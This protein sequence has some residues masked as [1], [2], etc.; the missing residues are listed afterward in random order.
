MSKFPTLPNN[1]SQWQLPPSDTTY[2]LTQRHLEK[3]G[4]G[5]RLSFAMLSGTSSEPGYFQLKKGASSKP[6]LISAVKWHYAQRWLHSLPRHKSAEPEK[7]VCEHVPLQEI[8]TGWEGKPKPTEV[9]CSTGTLTWTDRRQWQP[10]PSELHW[11]LSTGRRCWGRAK[12][13]E[14]RCTE[15]R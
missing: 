14:R 4:V 11:L 13:K 6:L 8:K 3:L 12:T 10:N 9:A 2:T 5:E 15:G 1:S 7:R